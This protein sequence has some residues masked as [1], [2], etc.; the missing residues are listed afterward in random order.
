MAA[1]SSVKRNRIRVLRGR[2]RFFIRVIFVFVPLQR[3]KMGS[4][5]KKVKNL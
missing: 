3:K 2:V 4:V 1:Q 5:S